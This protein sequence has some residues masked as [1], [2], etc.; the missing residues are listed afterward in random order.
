MSRKWKWKLGN[1]WIFWTIWPW[2]VKVENQIT[3]ALFWALFYY[4][5]GGIFP[6]FWIKNLYSGDQMRRR[7]LV[8]WKEG[9]VVEQS[10]ESPPPVSRHPSPRRE[11]LY[12]SFQNISGETNYFIFVLLESCWFLGI[13]LVPLTQS[14]CQALLSVCSQA[15]WVAGVIVRLD[16]HISGRVTKSQVSDV[17]PYDQVYKSFC[18]EGTGCLF[19]SDIDMFR[20]EE[21]SNERNR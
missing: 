9:S 20:S 14:D 5:F 11:A 12:T 19:W 15:D 2:K 17:R 16:C 1:I 3:G 4:F 8:G 10:L 21:P 18:Q 13:S 7:L 6:T